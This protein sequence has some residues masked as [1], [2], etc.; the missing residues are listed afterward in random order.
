MDLEKIRKDTPGCEEVIHFNNAGAAL[1]SQPVLDAVTNH[2]HLESRIG[3]YEAEYR[4]ENSIEH[5]YDSIA[6]LIGCQRNEVA[7]IENATRAWDMA[8][9]SIPFRSGDRILTAKAEYASN[10][11]S[12]LQTA[13]KTGVQID[14]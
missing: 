13:K 14:V 9:Y 5:L 10:F 7:V 8:F 1:M 2:L 11:I 3:A 4:Q 12:Y 6:K